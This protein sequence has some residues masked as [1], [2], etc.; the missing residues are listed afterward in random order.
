MWDVNNMF[1]HDGAGGLVQAL[2]GDAFST[3]II[4]LDVAN[5]NIAAGK[6]GVY[7]VIISTIA[8]NTLTSLEIILET[9]TES[10]FSTALK[11]VETKHYA[12]A[13]LT[14]GQIL[15]N[16][17]LNV[18]LYQRWLRLKFNVVGSNPST[19]SLQGGFTDGPESAEAQLDQ[20]AL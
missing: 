5:R 2:T 3:N 12:L 19:G 9:D 18:A 4:D 8:F 6:K 16:Q 20:V 13:D 11:Q 10:T 14:A 7:L 15:W 17:R 1:T